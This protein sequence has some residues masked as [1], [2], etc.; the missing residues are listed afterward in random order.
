VRRKSWRR[1]FRRCGGVS[2]VDLA[3][4]TLECC[5]RAGIHDGVASASF[6]L[7]ELVPRSGSWL[8]LFFAAPIGPRSNAELSYLRD[9]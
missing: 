5:R 3:A 8:L 4:G 6:E 9:R 1:S 7:F 2:L